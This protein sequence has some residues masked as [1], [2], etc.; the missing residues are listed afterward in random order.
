MMSF[1]GLKWTKSVFI[2]IANPRPELNATASAM[3]LPY[4]AAGRG[5]F[6][7]SNKVHAADVGQEEGE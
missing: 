6:A 3:V 1:A 7:E 5:T 4:R 2:V